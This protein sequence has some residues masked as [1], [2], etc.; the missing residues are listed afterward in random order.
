MIGLFYMPSLDAALQLEAVLYGS[1]ARCVYL[2]SDTTHINFL[3]SGQ[4]SISVP[5]AD[6]ALEKGKTDKMAIC[7]L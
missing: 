2:L 1:T 7:K 3:S 6:E 4:Q 5:S